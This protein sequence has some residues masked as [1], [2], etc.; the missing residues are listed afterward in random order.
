MK[1]YTENFT[2]LLNKHITNK[3]ID[4]YEFMLRVAKL[5]AEII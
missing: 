5:S 1:I 3:E 4:T 2:I